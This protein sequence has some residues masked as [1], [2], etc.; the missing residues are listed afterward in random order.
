MPGTRILGSSLSGR[1]SGLLFATAKGR[2]V[3]IVMSASSMAMRY[4]LEY[5]SI[6]ADLS[7]DGISMGMLKQWTGW[8]AY[9]DDGDVF[10]FDYSNLSYINT[11]AG[12]ES[13]DY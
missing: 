11:N 7:S 2:A 12:E 10:S 3:V 6:S 9:E 13:A 5:I 4:I 1:R 8:A